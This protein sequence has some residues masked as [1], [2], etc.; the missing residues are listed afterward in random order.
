[1]RLRR[2][3]LLALAVV[4][5]LASL[6]ASAPFLSRAETV[7]P[8]KPGVVSF[9]AFGDSG[10]GG[11]G[12]RRVAES[13]AKVIGANPVDFALMLGDN[14][15]PDGLA[16]ASDPLFDQL[17]R[18]VY[19]KERFP[20][21]FYITLGNHEYHR[22]AAA[23]LK[24]GARDARWK[25]PA[26]RYA[27]TAPLSDRESVLFLCLDTTAVDAPARVTPDVDVRPPL[28]G[29]AEELA[30]A[31]GAAWRFVFGHH[32]FLTS[33]AHGESEPM[34]K[35]LAPVLAAGKT[36]AYLCGHDHILESLSPVAGVPQIVSGG[37]GG[38]DRATPIVH[39]R[40]ESLFRQ[41]GGGF[42]RAEIRPDA[43]TFVFH[44]VEGVVR[45]TR[46]LFPQPKVEV[47]K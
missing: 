33:G 42:V 7:K 34:L 27:F 4:P 17:F 41:T 47:T 3:L 24:L 44:D 26:R 36:D 37:G 45:H 19:L 46:T 25:M 43:A 21:P 15:Y 35:Q 12:Q 9:L 40:R 31:R 10:T 38:W 8:R 23:N 32:A 5:A 6:H 29:V 30:A 39:V 11:P 22:N 1:M 18:D 13:M 2:A 14:F 28:E 16:S 20:F